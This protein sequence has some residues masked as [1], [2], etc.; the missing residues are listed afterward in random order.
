MHRLIAAAC[1]LSFVACGPP[2]AIVKFTTWGEEYIEQGIPAAKFEDGWN[3]KFTKFLIV[4]KDIVVTDDKGTIASAQPGAKAFDLVKK[5]PVEVYAG[6][7]PAKAWDVVRYSI[8]PDENA[9]A[10][11]IEA[12]DLSLMKSRGASIMLFGSG[13][14]GS[15][16]KSFEW[17]LTHN[18]LYDHC[19]RAEKGGKGVVVVPAKETE[20]QL[21]IHG[22]HLF[23]DQLSGDAKLRFDAIAN[24]DSNNDNRVTL[25]ELGIV[26][27]ETLPQ[28]QY[29]T[30]GVS[31]VRSLKD[32]I[33]HSARTIGHFDGEGECTPRAR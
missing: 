3:V 17:T 30:S 18:T 14:K 7:A 26:Q 19:E 33:S 13:T 32:F 6:T 10:G 16:T 8:A 4:V 11:N 1:A 12:A 25:D 5:G 22:D 23:Y 27:V 28:G 15:V 9:V 29:G 24:A 20:V 21:T 2:I 31:N